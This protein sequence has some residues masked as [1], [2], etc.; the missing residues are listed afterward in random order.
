MAPAL[1]KLG[2]SAEAAPLRQRFE[3]FA[4]SERDSNNIHYRAEAR[5]LLALA[6]KN[7]GRADEAKALIAG[8]LAARPDLLPAWL[9][10][11]GD[12][13]DALPKLTLRLYGRIC[14]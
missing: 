5:Y 7:S 3:D 2:R 11:R 4:L 13:V 14:G 12:V 1:E 9:E 6:R 8:A 10:L